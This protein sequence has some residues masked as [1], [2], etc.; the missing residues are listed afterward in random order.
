MAR[1]LNY[2]PALPECLHLTLNVKQHARAVRPFLDSLPK[3]FTWLVES[4]V[5]TNSIK[6]VSYTMSQLR[7][8]GYIRLAQDL[9]EK[10]NE[11]FGKGQRKAAV[12]A[13]KEGIVRCLE[14]LNTNPSDEKEKGA[15]GLLAVLRSNLALTYLV[16]GEGM[17]ARKALDV[18][19]AAENV[20]PS[21]AKAYVSANR[22]SSE[23]TLSLTS[24]D[25]VANLAIS[26]FPER[27][28][29]WEPFQLHRRLLRGG[30]VVRSFKM[31]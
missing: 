20:C 10:G 22:Y 21:Y 29:C 26:A 11:S 16:P 31:I 1:P 18:A 27:T 28:R 25:C 30:C 14:A 6:E 5:L 3:P 8:D 15:V 7:F 19:L 9:K 23:W 4:E 2:E 12:K 24:T 13:F 17:N